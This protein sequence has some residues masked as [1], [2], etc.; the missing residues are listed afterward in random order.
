MVHGL[1]QLENSTIMCLGCLTGKRNISNILKQSQWSACSILELIHA[2]ICGPIEPVSNSEK[3]YII[4]FID[5]FSQKQWVYLLSKKSEALQCF[6]LLKT[7]MEKK[8]G[9]F[10]KCLRADRGGKF[11]SDEFKMF[12]EKEGIRRQLTNAYMPH[13]NGVAETKNRTVMNM[14][15]CMLIAK[16]VPKTF[17]AE[18]IKWMFYVL[19]RSPT[20]AVQNI[21]P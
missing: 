4:C 3:M 20:M 1:P 16:G 18:A 9:Q 6:K 21:T 19:I 17:W 14:V 8:T 11:N 12:C 13:Q 2:D 5:D 15:K 7:Y 10:I